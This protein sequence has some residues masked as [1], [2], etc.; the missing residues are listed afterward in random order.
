VTLGILEAV[1][2][3]KTPDNP[4]SRSP[5]GRLRLAA[6]LV[7][8][9]ISATSHAGRVVVPKSFPISA[10]VSSGAGPAA[11]DRA[12]VYIYRGGK[13]TGSSLDNIAAIEFA[14]GRSDEDVGYDFIV[15]TGQAPA[16]LAGGPYLGPDVR[17]GWLDRAPLKPFDFTVEVWAVD[18]QGRRSASSL[19]LDVS[20]NGIDQPN[21]VREAHLAFATRMA[22]GVVCF[23]TVIAGLAFL[24]VAASPRENLRTRF[25]FHGPKSGR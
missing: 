1:L 3:L 14:M 24:L 4:D 22:V 12:D 11:P 15:T 18:R 19:N 7:A 6:L 23:V 17:F 20:N 9:A 10:E 2:T 16:Q 8:C 5:V 21:L 25:W 13:N